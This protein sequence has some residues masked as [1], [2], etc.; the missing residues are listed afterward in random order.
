VSKFLKMG[1]GGKVLRLLLRASSRAR[2]T[3]YGIYVFTEHRCHKME[4]N[5]EKTK[6]M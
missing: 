6:V 4:I 3:I 2:I 1:E 5:V